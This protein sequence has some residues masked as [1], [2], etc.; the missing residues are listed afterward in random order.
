MSVADPEGNPRSD[1]MI[2]NRIP[3]ALPWAARDPNRPLVGGR[4]DGKKLAPG[5]RELLNTLDQELY[6]T[7]DARDRHPQGYVSA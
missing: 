6:V 3:Q 4:H 2:V 5:G 1:G 7:L